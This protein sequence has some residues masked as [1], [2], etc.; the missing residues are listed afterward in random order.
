MQTLSLVLIEGAEIFHFFSIQFAV[1]VG[2]ERKRTN[3]LS[4]SLSL[5]IAR[6]HAQQ[7]IMAVA[8]GRV[9][10][11]LGSNLLASGAADRNADATVFVGNVDEN[12]SESLVWELFT[13]AGPVVSAYMPKD[14]VTGAH[15]GYGFVEL[16]SE[17]DAAYAI[18][19]LNMIRLNG[20]PLRVNRSAGGAPGSGNNP[21]AAADVG[22]N[23]FIGNL[24]PD[25]DEKLL[26]DTFAAFGVIIDS[27]KVMRDP[28][29][30]VSKGFAFVSYDC[31]EASDAAVE[32]MNG[33]FLANRSIVV[34]YA[35]RKDVRGERHGTPAERLLAAQFKAREAGARPN[36]R[37]SAGPAA[38]SKAAPGAAA[39]APPR[40]LPPP[41]P[42]Y[43]MMMPAPPPM[44]VMM[45]PPP[46]GW[47]GGQMPPPP[48]P[49]GWQGGHLPPPLPQG[50][51]GGGQR[52]MPPPPPPPPMGWQGP[53]SG[54]GGMMMPPPPP[55][56]PQDDDD[57]PP[58]PPPD[59]DE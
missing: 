45:P 49:Q 41:P 11:A 15:Q 55:P 47:Q 37:F 30:G 59:E 10:A 1:G 13:Q 25:V 9:S 33:Q 2:F 53:H 58:P 3:S 38:A 26:Y 48:P 20:K 16:A 21:N 8:G 24:D 27:P 39:A 51:Q 29:T 36:T 32:A 54:G 35:F 12:V 52:M 18:K 28:E 5:F 19:I 43:G 7:H 23:L 6:S 46:Q 50:W 44:M 31:F 42:Q 4:L 56:P 22:A 57:I 17:E 34:Q 14:R 40:T